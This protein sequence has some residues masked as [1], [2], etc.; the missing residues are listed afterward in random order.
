MMY[1][2]LDDDTNSSLEMAECVVYGVAD[3]V[4]IM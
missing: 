1:S 4:L 2:Q 3:A